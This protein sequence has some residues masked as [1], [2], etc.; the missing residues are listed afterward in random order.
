MSVR[1][2]FPSG[3]VRGDFIHSYGSRLLVVADFFKG[4]RT[5][6]T[7]LSLVQK[8]NYVD[9]PKLLESIWQRILCIST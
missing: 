3:S 6:N 1:L 8:Y 2:M 9:S 7:L 4:N 5:W